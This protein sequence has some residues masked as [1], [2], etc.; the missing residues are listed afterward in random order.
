MK[1]KKI[2]SLALA[3]ILAVSMLT[4]CGEGESSSTVNPPVN[5]A[6]AS[7]IAAA[8][9]AQLSGDQADLLSFEANSKLAN[10]MSW[11]TGDHVDRLIVTDALIQGASRPTL[12]T[13]GGLS[14][15]ALIAQELDGMV[16]GVTAMG[17]NEVPTNVSNNQAYLYVW[18]IDGSVSST[19]VIA[20]TVMNGNGGAG[21]GRGLMDVFY[22]ENNMVDEG[23][24]DGVNDSANIDGNQTHVGNVDHEYKGYAEMV[25]VTNANSS[26]TAWGV[27]VRIVKYSTTNT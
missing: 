17:V 25:K 2:V 18:M 3:G 12:L 8:L 27:A 15:P 21:A 6:P 14:V 7:A 1:L 13:A 24:T 9:N 5:N 22:D 20:S 23:I 19:D 11:M 4:A 16:P 26:D 10:A